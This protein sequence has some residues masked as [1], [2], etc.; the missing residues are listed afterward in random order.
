[1]GDTSVRYHVPL[2]KFID[3]T[4]IVDG[5]LQAVEKTYYKRDKVE[6]GVQLY[7]IIHEK[8]DGVLIT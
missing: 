3:G 8:I 6:Y 2:R 1:M 4:M 5:V 7:K